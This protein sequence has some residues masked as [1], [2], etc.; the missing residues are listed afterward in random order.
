[1]SNRREFE[2]AFVGLKPGI[3]EF[4]YEIRDKFFIPYGDQ[5]FSNCNANVK[6]QLD[7]HNGFMLLKFDIG[8]S[9]D[10]S[11]D[12]CGNP[13]PL[14]L[15]DEFKIVVK[16]VDNPEEMNDQEEDPDVYYISRGES[17]LHI[18]NWIYEFINLSIPMQKMCGE[19]EMGGPKCNKEVLEKLRQMEND[20]KEEKNPLWK[21][22]DQFKNLE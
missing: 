9:V 15:W 1:M 14:Q 22:L 3:H 21:G 20:V 8:G 17:H 10:V 6:L 13:L 5:D 16:M 11:C 4:D 19:D 2:I 7:K 12:R 18:A